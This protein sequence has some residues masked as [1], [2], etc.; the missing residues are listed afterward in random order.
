M[1]DTSTASSALARRPVGQ[2]HPP[3]L[4]VWG[5]TMRPRTL[6]DLIADDDP[7]ETWFHGLTKVEQDRVQLEA[8]ERFRLERAQ[9]YAAKRVA[10]VLAP[11]REWVERFNCSHTWSEL[12]TADAWQLLGTRR[13]GVS[14][15][16]RPEK[17]RREGLSATIN[18]DGTD[19][20][21]VF[22][23][24]LAWLP[25]G[26]YYDRWSYYVHS[27]YGGDFKA[28]ARAWR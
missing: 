7:G 2:G 14:E 8:F 5:V 4:Y 24:S 10:D 19:R 15:W 28:A 26:Q 17:D 27:E 20:L 23:T 25:S 18:A 9:L 6:V 13:D 16:C 11:R 21:Y 1:F 12:L 3:A 22:T